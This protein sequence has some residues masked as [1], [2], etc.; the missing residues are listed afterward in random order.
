MQLSFPSELPEEWK[1]FSVVQVNKTDLGRKS[2][3]MCYCLDF[4]HTFKRGIPNE[5]CLTWLYSESN[6]NDADTFNHLAI[7]IGYTLAK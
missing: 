6:L 2:E 1:L 5:S 7:S 4:I 3:A